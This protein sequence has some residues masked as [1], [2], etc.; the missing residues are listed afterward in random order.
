MANSGKRFTVEEVIELVTSVDTERADI[1]LEPP[2]CESS[3]SAEDS[4]D[5]GSLIYLSGHHLDVVEDII[6]YKNVE[7]EKKNQ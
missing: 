1:S 7:R 6:L 3:V 5:G 2:D 4:G